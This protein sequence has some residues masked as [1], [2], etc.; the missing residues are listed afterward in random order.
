MMWYDVDGRSNHLG[1]VPGPDRHTVD[2]VSDG[3]LVVENSRDDGFI[4]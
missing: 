2:R 4:G 3:H 1:V